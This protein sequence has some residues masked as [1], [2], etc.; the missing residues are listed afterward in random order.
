MSTRVTRGRK[1]A[2]SKAAVQ[3]VEEVQ[4]PEEVDVPKKSAKK[5]AKR[6]AD[7]AVPEPSVEKKPTLS[8]PSSATPVLASVPSGFEQKVPEGIVIPS[9][10]MWHKTLLLT[11]FGEC[12]GSTKIAGF[13]YDGCLAKTS[14]FKKGP[15]AWSVLFATC[16]PYL[17]SLHAQG[18]KVVIFTNQA[19]IGK[20]KGSKQK[21]VSE[22]VA[23]LGGFVAQMGIPIQVLAA[24]DK[25]AFRKPGLGMWDFFCKHFNEGVIPDKTTSFFVGDAAGRK[26]DHG[27]TDLGFAKAVGIKFYTETDFFQDNAHKL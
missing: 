4:E 20:A 13:D 7:S 10:W 2:P 6:P 15:E 27:D 1:A 25:D 5:G 22:K 18:Y 3:E 19:E 21:S 9:P 26:K 16:K 14:L 8:T 24:T 11:Q 12:K 23:R 17:T